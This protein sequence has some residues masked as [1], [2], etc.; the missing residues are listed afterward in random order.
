MT[1]K[2]DVWVDNVEYFK[3][4]D[5]YTIEID[6]KQGE[7]RGVCSGFVLGNTWKNNG[8]DFAQYYLTYKNDSKVGIN[9]ITVPFKVKRGTVRYVTGNAT[10]SV[11]NGIVY[12]TFSNY[13]NGLVP[14]QEVGFEIQIV[15][16]DDPRIEP[17]ETETGIG[18]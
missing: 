7:S 1:C 8:D 12:V 9:S 11:E 18:D 16:S 14:D 6:V 10:G 4:G 17:L 13:G 15:G 3:Q 5:T 2:Q